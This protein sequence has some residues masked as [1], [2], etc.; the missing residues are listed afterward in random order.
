MADRLLNR[1]DFLWLSY[2]L[3]GGVLLTACQNKQPDPAPALM[4]PAGIYINGSSSDA[5]TFKKQTTGGVRNPTDCQ[6]VWIEN[7]GSRL[8]A[9]LNEKSF[10]LVVPIQPGTNHLTAVCQHSNQEE[11]LSPEKVITGRLQQRP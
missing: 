10:S 2:A 5:W 8:P 4:T 9:S 3:A 6:A 11:E 1:R 7:S